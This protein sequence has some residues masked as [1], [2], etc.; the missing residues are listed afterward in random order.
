[1]ALS[2]PTLFFPGGAARFR[3]CGATGFRVRGTAGF[4][5]S[6]TAG[7]RF[8]GTARFRLSGT[9]RFNGRALLLCG[10]ARYNHCRTRYQAGDADACKDLFKVLL[11]HHFSLILSIF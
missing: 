5:L 8:P 9:A 7:F 10:T 1:M 6:G 11:V 2:R 4:R 3:A